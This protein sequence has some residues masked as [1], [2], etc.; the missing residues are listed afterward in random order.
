MRKI[1]LSA[2]NQNKILGYFIEEAKEH[3]E[4]LEKGL[5]DLPSVTQDQ[6]WVNELF[7]AAH[8]VKGEAAML[9]YGSSIQ[10]TAHRLEDAF[11]R[12]QEY[13]NITVN[14]K[15]ESLFLSGFDTLKVLIEKLESPSGLSDEEAEKIMQAAEPQFVELQSYLKQLVGGEQSASTEASSQALASQIRHLLKEML[16]QFKQDATPE[17]RQQLQAVCDRLT[18]LV[19]YSPGW[20]TLVE[21]AR[22]AISNLNH[23]YRTLAPVVIKELKQGSDYIELGKPSEIYPSNSL[24]RLASANAPQILIPVEPKAAATI[25]THAFNQ[26]QRSQIVQLLESAAG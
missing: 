23:S 19:P 1:A 6:E 17:S 5:L 13:E 15:L 12:L 24:Q 22:K 10:K 2:E 9:D 16:E 20:Q 4:T 18:A 26:Q 7:R 11:K 21:T 25:L 3:L 14:Q 8:S